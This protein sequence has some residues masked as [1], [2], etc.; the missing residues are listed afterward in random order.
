MKKIFKSKNSERFSILP[1]P[2]FFNKYLVL[3]ML[4]VLVPA[5]C[6]QLCAQSA[7]TS[8]TTYIG[9]YHIKC[10]GQ[11][12][13]TINANPNFGT[14][15]Y[16]F[17][18]NTG[19]N[20]AQISNKPAGI[21][22]VTITDQ[23]NIS[24]TDTFELLQPYLL[25]YQSVVSNFNGYQIDA[26]GA[27][28]G[29]IQLSATGGT[30]PYRYYWSDADSSVIKK[31]LVAGTYQFTITDANQC[32]TSGSY[33]LNEPGALQVS[34]S[35]IQQ[36]TCFKSNNGKATINITGGL[37]NYDVVWDNGSF[38]MS[39]DNL[40]EGYNA[41]RIYERGRA[42]LDTGITLTQPDAIEV[43]FAKSNYNGYNVSCVDCFNGSISTT[44]TGGTAPYTYLWND[45]NN[46]ST[47][48]LSNLNGGEY[49]LMIMDAN[50]CKMSSTVQ[51]SMPN[52]KDWSRYGNSNTDTS[53]FI[54]STDT[55]ALRFK[56][57]NQEVL[58]MAG[59]GN[60]GIGTASPTEKLEV[61]GV[62]KASGLKLNNFELDIRP[63]SA[64]NPEIISMGAV[65]AGPSPDPLNPIFESTC[66]DPLNIERANLFNGG[67]VYKVKT[68]IQNSLICK[69]ADPTMYVG[70]YGCDGAIEV[71]QTNNGSQSFSENKLLI[72]TLCGKDV[73]V[74]KTDAGNLIANYRLGVGVANPTEK[75]EVNGNGIIFGK[76]GIGSAAPE[77]DLHIKNGISNSFIIENTQSPNKFKIEAA[78][79]YGRLSSSGGFLFFL[80]S[81]Q[82]VT[83]VSSEFVISKNA[84]HSGQAG[85]T[86]LF[87][88][89]N[90]GTAYLKDLWV[91]A[92]ATNGAFPDYV[93]AKDY[94]LK[95]LAEVKAYYLKNHHLPDLP[96]ATQIEAQGGVSMSDLLI[97]LTKIVEENT[98][99][100]TQQDEQI[101]QLQ[102]ENLKLKKAIEKLAK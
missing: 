66:I 90:D 93:F 54:G 80:N 55:S 48:N 97:K 22:V 9:G 67:A 58:K 24:Q 19:E 40:K 69:N 52:P 100:L 53:E 30:P 95:T 21:Y 38:S 28:S 98:I 65:T 85:G 83:D 49:E 6:M 23:N 29:S 5:A 36:L 89:K 77:A 62:I 47:P 7:Y 88:I 72:N 14:P 13:G 27:H 8:S 91:K 2:L 64:V 42:V 76:V 86:E 87:K 78:N 25:N 63:P 26:H 75:F 96:S 74:G 56:I 41:V 60:I 102:A 32:S 84:S 16:T 20:T 3:T 18:W 50:A 37:G 45:A 61:N 15:P 70:L 73:I 94:K 82:D 31:D 46:S 71:N 17:L 59:N 33:T 35:N 10:H 92:P 81:D 44:V 101:K 1:H 99:Y 34:F 57:N 43:Q 51:L 11:S 79:G 39:P 4:H 12:T 68:I